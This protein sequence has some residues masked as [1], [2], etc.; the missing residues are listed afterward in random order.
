MSTLKAIFDEQFDEVVFDKALCQRIIRFSQWFMTRNDDHSAFFGG[1]LLGVNPIRFYDSDREKWYEEVIDIDES[2]LEN[3]FKAA[4]AIDF[5]YNV[6]SDVFN[7]TPIYLCHR[8]RMEKGISKSLVEEAQMHAF[9]V[10]HYRF[11]T[12]LLV[13]R[14]RYPAD[15]EIAQATYASLS[16][17]FDI[18]KYG[19]W[20]N[21]LE[22]RSSNLASPESIYN[23]VIN[24]FS[25]DTSKGTGAS[26]I[27]VVTDTQGRIR[28]LVN[29]IYA[30]HVNNKDLGKRVSITT[31]IQFDHLGETVLKDRKGGYASL[32]RYANEVAL[33]PQSLIKPELVD[34]INNLM[35]TMPPQ[36]LIESLKYLSTHYQQPKMEALELIVKEA[37]L[38]AFD[39]MHRNRTLVRTNDL[40]TILVRLRALLTASR[41]TDPVII[42]LRNLT[43]QLVLKAVNTKN[44]AVIASVRTGLLLYIVLRTL[45]KQHY[46]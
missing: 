20:R 17:R 39:F 43:E 32:L 27:R 46:D 1:V 6:M 35:S 28:E 31:D 12:S 45:S 2:L 37:L 10:L 29:K 41:T 14:F 13:T 38:F 9:M 34:V 24:D 4:S 5:N 25:P 22:A 40:A 36:L 44:T 3:G 7:Y 8:L 33:L 19:S 26:V 15:P 21:L 18:K 16:M 23:G 30:I 42:R 11:L